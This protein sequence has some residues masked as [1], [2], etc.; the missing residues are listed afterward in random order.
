MTA[1]TLL[2]L[3]GRGTAR[4]AGQVSRTA[5]PGSRA[6]AASVSARLPGS[7]GQGMKEAT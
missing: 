4:R 3:S 2:S 5:R 7:D 6:D 1:P